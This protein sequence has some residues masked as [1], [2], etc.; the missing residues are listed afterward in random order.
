[1][2]SSSPIS[3]AASRR[4]FLQATL[5]GGGAIAT[6]LAHAQGV[7]GAKP[8]RTTDT[9]RLAWGRGGLPALAKTRGEFEKLLAKDGIKVQWI[10][11]FP[12]H[13]PSLQAVTGGSAD[14]GFG[15]ST[16]PALAAMIAGSPLVFTQFAIVEPRSTAI[17]AKDGSGIDKVQDLVGKSVAVNRSGLGEFLLVAALEKH[18]IDRSKV[19]F[20]YLN[21]PD[22][23][24]AFAQ[25]KIDAWSMWSPG[26]DI[27]RTEYKAHDVFFEGRDLEFLIDFNSYVTHRKF[28]EEN[29]AIVKAVN[30]AYAA[31]A[32]WV[33]Q[34]PTEAETLQQKDSGYS[35]AVRDTLI[36][37][38]RRWDVHGVQD[39][40]F[41]QEFQKA[42]DWLSDRKILPEK[43]KV[44]DYLARI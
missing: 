20:V 40:K 31:E 9:V 39:A 3:A 13:A 14:F 41:I 38:Q 44:R 18:G 12:N 43:V 8:G 23:G 5:L 29:L 16:T 32:Q 30:A 15:G 28:A 7:Q 27:A 35:D 37:L 25:G 22:A 6:G 2:T 33:T 11:P 26:V 1:M 24:P 10:G 42:A 19:R 21:P 36:K 17:I 34:H 4:S